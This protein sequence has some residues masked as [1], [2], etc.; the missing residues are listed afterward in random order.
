MREGKIPPCHA[1]EL[2]DCFRAN[3][4]DLYRYACFITR[5]DQAL[6]AD[7][8]AQW[9][10]FAEFVRRALHAAADQVEPRRDGLAPIRART[11]ITDVLDEPMLDPWRLRR[12][13]GS[14]PSGTSMN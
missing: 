1:A 14:L 10:A 13:S 11:G 3:A 4:G 5:G 9:H 2:A 12:I 8:P 6:S 7:T